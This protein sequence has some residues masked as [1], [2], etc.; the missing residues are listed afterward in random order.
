MRITLCVFFGLMCVAYA[1]GV[2]IDTVIIGDAGNPNDPATGALY[3]GVNY[4]YRIGKYEV[5]V[6]QYVAFL[7]AVA[8]TDTY[9]L[10]NTQME[11]FAPLASIARVGT[12]GSYTYSAIGSPNHAISMISWGDAARFANWLHN[13]QP[14]GSQTPAPR[15][16]V[17]TL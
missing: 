14:I 12:S 2:T 13:G 3:G 7:N 8:A 1:R 10:F 15:K 5:N 9:G 17:H 16:M 11:T 4:D 6:G